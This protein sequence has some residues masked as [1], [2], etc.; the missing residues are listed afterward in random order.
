MNQ[1]FDYVSMGGR[2]R[3]LRKERHVTQSQLAELLDISPA[4]MGHIERGTRVPSVDTLVRIADVLDVTLDVIVRGEA[5]ST[6]PLSETV[7]PR[8][9]QK[10][11]DV[12][13]TLDG[14]LPDGWLEDT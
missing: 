13:R 5:P 14:Y 10:L 9:V 6:Q 12:I 3:R 7:E 2:I 11:N 1:S 4:F 8:R